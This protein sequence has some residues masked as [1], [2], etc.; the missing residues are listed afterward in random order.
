MDEYLEELG[1]KHGARF[2]AKTPH[3]DVS[4]NWG[5]Y[6]KGLFTC[7]FFGSFPLLKVPFCCHENNGEKMSPSPILSVINTITI[8]T[9]PW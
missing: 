7:N 4:E 5:N 8:G 9:V 3:F 1:F 2:G 6:S